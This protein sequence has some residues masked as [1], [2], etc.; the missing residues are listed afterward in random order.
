MHYLTSGFLFFDIF[1]SLPVSF[2]ELVSQAECVAGGAEANE[3]IDST[4]FRFARVVKPLRWIKIAR[5]LKIG[6]GGGMMS[7]LMD[8]WNIS[9]CKSISTALRCVDCIRLGTFFSDFMLT[10]HCLCSERETR[11][12]AW[13][14]RLVHPSDGLLVVA[15]ES[16]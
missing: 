3:S 2:F 5:V 1:T 9:P 13:N 8:R 16:H 14:A 7:N 4:Q 11:K 15:M 6:K 12:R 10:P